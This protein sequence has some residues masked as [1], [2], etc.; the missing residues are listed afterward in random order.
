MLLYLCPVIL[1]DTTNSLIERTDNFFVLTRTICE[2]THG[3]SQL[4]LIFDVLRKVSGSREYGRY[5]ACASLL[6]M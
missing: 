6:Q 5:K 4:D 1:I 3:L 2:F